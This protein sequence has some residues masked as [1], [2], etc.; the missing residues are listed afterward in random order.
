MRR[1]AKSERCHANR[2][3]HRVKAGAVARTK[4]SA[5]AFA[6]DESVA[7]AA[8]DRVL[9]VIAAQVEDASKRSILQHTKAASR[10]VC[11]E[12]TW[13]KRSCLQN[14]TQKHNELRKRRKL[15]R[16]KRQEQERNKFAMQR[17]NKNQSYCKLLWATN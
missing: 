11:D 8:V 14:E 9:R 2:F 10:A 16:K 5:A 1:N 6:D 17:K 3:I 13:N 12:H 7:A 15:N 4:R